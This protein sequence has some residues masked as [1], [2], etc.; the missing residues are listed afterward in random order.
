MKRGLDGHRGDV[1]RPKKGWVLD[2][3]MVVVLILGG[4]GTRKLLWAG[5]VPSRLE[6]LKEKK[7]S[8]R[9]GEIWTEPLTGMQF[10]Y[11]PEGCFQM[12]QTRAEEAYLIRTVGE[13]EYFRYFADEKPRHTVCVKGFWMGRYEVTVGQW[14]MFVHETGYR[15]KG[16]RFWRCNGMANP[17]G[18]R[19]DWNEPVCCV[20]W[21]D[22]QAFIAWLNRKTGW[23]F[24]LP[25]EAEWEYAARAGTQTFWFWGSTVDA[26][27]CRYASVA[28]KAHGWE[29][30]FPCDDGYSFTAPIGHF[31][32]NKFGLYDMLGNVWEWC[33][34]WYDRY[35]Y[36]RSPRDNP[37]GPGSGIYRV[38]RGGSWR[39][40]PSYV[41]CANR[42]N[43][44]P[45][46]RDDDLGFRLIRERKVIK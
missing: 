32:P 9:S 7:P 11:V 38:I 37:M 15:G 21:Y 1:R 16:A 43:D 2:V 41:R 31:L 25:T 5:D 30:N 36:A 19:Q 27:A 26:T 20:S 4:A 44:K 23:K 35:Y 24:R 17:K 10:V 34:D 40:Y 22:A 18:F 29:Y 6:S 33:Q 12:G 39:Y 8:P 45:D 28:D 13:D 42:G 14:R 46:S 3:F